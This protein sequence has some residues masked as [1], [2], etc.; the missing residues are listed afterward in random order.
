[1]G[2]GAAIIAICSLLAAFFKAWS[3]GKP[4]REEKKRD[5]EAKDVA[6]IVGEKDIAAAATHIAD[7][8]RRLRERNDI[9]PREQ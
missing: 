5:E 3:N 1:M 9:S 7:I 8:H 6:R 2:I 4:A